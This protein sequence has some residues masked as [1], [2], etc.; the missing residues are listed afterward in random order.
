MVVVEV[1]VEFFH[2]AIINQPVLIDGGFQQVTVV[3]DD[4]NGTGEILQRYSQCLAHFDIQMVGRF[5]HDQQVGFH[6]CHTRQCQTCFLTAGEGFDDFQGAITMKTKA[7]EEVTDFLFRCFWSQALQNQSAAGFYIKGFELML[8]VIADAQVFA[9]GT[10][11]ADHWQFFAQGFQQSRF[12]CTV[13]SEQT[14]AV[15]WYD[16][17]FHVR[18]NGFFGIT[19]SGMVDGQQWRRHLFVGRKFETKWRVD[20]RRGNQLHTLQFF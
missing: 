4:K 2:L 13:G 17:E 18:Q 12:T 14:D 16:A 1:A 6:P 5:V 15:A 3:A 10:L 9:F 8:S 19:Q 20:M 7:A 11:A